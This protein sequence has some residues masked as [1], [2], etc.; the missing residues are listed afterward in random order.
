[1]SMRTRTRGTST[2]TQATNQEPQSDDWFQSG[3]EGFETAEKLSQNTKNYVNRFWLKAG[4]SA[5]LVVLDD[6][7]GFFIHEYEI[8]D[9]VKKRASY[10]TVRPDTEYDPL[11]QL[12]GVDTRFKDPYYVM[13]LTVMDLRPYTDKQGNERSHSKKLLPIKKM[14]MAKFK[15][16][17]E[18]YGT[19]RGLILNMV[20]DNNKQA[21]IG[22]P[23]WVDPDDFRE[24]DSEFS[25]QKILSEDEIFEFFGH[26]A[27]IGQ[28]GK[29]VIKEKDADCYPMDYR[30]VLKPASVDELCRRW[31]AT[32]NV[33][34]TEAN[35][36]VQDEEETQSSAARPSNSLRRR[37]ASGSTSQEDAGDEAPKSALR[38]RKTLTKK[39]VE[40][41]EEEEVVDEDDAPPFD[42]DGEDSD[43]WYEG[44]DE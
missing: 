36:G 11:Q 24:T 3:D 25:G 20:R 37:K 30:D 6:E 43:E 10:E 8:F 16:Y 38:K 9:P 19:Y 13:Y 31:G 14:Q 22:D 28:D 12:V 42:A 32:P 27:V 41:P 34:S 1:M 7:K 21:K 4:D 26:D 39:P 15:R 40:Q 44:D 29:T 17:Y 35:R 5:E 2:Q 23:E 33:G 18:K